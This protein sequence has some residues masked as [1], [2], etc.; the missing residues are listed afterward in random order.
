MT[1]W[2]LTNVV[3]V[4]LCDRMQR[5]RKFH[6]DKDKTVLEQTREDEPPEE[7]M[8][9]LEPYVGDARARLTVSGA[10]SSSV[11]YHKAEAFVSVSVSCNNDMD[12]VQQVHDFL[13]PYVQGLIDEDHREMSLIRDTVLSPQHRVH[14]QETSPPIQKAAPKGLPPAVSKG[15]VGRPPKRGGT[16][17]PPKGARPKPSLKR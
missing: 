6:N 2:M 7:L 16:V 5:S 10:L 13:R 15:K 17:S 3:D 4:S 12:D 9:Q 1:K 14:G 8:S 11:E